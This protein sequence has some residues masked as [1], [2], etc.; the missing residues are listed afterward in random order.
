MAF[1]TLSSRIRAPRNAKLAQSPA[2]QIAGSEVRPSA[3]TAMPLSIVSPA[4]SARSDRGRDADADDDEIDRQTLPV[5]QFRAVDPPLAGQPRQ[6]RAFEDAHAAP[7]RCSARIASEVSGAQT[8]CR[9][10]GAASISV[11]S[12]PA[13]PRHRRR[14]QPDEAAADDQHMPAGANS[15][16][17]RSISASRRTG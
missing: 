15:P 1:C 14:L 10:R 13:L 7:C 9:M 11:T 3:S 4:S 17:I 8:R 16:A 12:R 2:A 5:G 6:P